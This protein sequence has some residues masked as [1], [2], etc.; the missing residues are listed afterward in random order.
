MIPT[1]VRIKIIVS[2]QRKYF[3]WIGV[4]ILSTFQ[5]LWLTKQDHNEYGPRVVHRR[6]F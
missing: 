4:S 2:P 3:V 5:Y 1:S 6:C